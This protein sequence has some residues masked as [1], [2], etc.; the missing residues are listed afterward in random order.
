MLYGTSKCF[1]CLLVVTDLQLSPDGVKL[2]YKLSLEFCPIGIGGDRVEV[3]F[4]D[5][6]VE[7]IADLPVSVDGHCRDK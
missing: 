3:D 4:S 5:H 6:T 7:E 1:R 2:S